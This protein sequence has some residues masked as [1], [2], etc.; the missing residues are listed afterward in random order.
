MYHE[1]TKREI[2]GGLMGRRLA[3]RS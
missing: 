3:G 2:Q 1:T